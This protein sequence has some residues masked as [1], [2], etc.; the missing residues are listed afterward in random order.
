MGYRNI[1][2]KGEINE[3]GKTSKEVIGTKFEHNN[4]CRALRSSPS[5]TRNG[6]S[7]QY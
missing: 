5:D 1:N 7:S 2:Y 4:E 3:K 6:I